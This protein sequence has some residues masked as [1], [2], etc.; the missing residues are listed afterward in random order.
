MLK[1]IMLKYCV[2]AVYNLRTVS[3]QLVGLHTV[4]AAALVGPVDSYPTYT[5]SKPV[6]VLGLVHHFFVHLTEVTDRLMP[7][8]HMTNKDKYKFKLRKK[9]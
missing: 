1:Q 3:R 4:P 2:Q 5:S 9:L 7:T 6:F 8:I